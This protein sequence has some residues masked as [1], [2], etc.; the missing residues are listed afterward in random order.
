MEVKTLSSTFCDSLIT[1]GNCNHF[2]QRYKAS[3]AKNIGFHEAK[4]DHKGLLL[5]WTNWEDA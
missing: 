1:G 2:V 3:I 5:P 4:Y